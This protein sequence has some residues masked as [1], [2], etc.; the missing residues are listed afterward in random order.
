MTHAVGCEK[1]IVEAASPMS[2]KSTPAARTPVDGP[3]GRRYLIPSDKTQA[4]ATWAAAVDK[5][6][7]ET[8]LKNGGETFERYRFADYTYNYAVVKSFYGQAAN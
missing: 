4:F 6:D 7:L 8:F 1:L 2:T 5:N 3:D